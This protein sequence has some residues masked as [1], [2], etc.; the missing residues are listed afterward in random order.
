MGELRLSLFF[1]RRENMAKKRKVILFNDDGSILEEHEFKG[2][3]TATH[4]RIY[5]ESVSMLGIRNDWMVLEE[6]QEANHETMMDFHKRNQLMYLKA[7]LDKKIKE[8]YA[9]IF[10]SKEEIEAEEKALMDDFWAKRDAI[11][12]TQSLQEL[13]RLLGLRSELDKEMEIPVPELQTDV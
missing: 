2:D 1:L 11:M 5:S 3:Y 4:D 6:G 12:A 13:R 8:I 7:D 10:K 9:D